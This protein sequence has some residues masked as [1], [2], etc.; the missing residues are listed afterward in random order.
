L[1]GS[2]SSSSDI[3]INPVIALFFNLLFSRPNLLSLVL[4]RLLSFFGH[5]FGDAASER[6]RANGVIHVRR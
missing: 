2:L 3:K 5:R 4:S 6:A 1:D